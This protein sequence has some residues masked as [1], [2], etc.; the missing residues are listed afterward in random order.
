MYRRD[1]FAPARNLFVIVLI[2]VL[3]NSAGS[4]PRHFALGSAI[5]IPLKT[6]L[7]T[8][9]QGRAGKD[10]DLLIIGESPGC[11]AQHE[12]AKAQLVAPEGSPVAVLETKTQADCNIT[13]RIRIPVDAGIGHVTLWV[14]ND[15]GKL[16]GTV[17]F[18]IVDFTPPGQIPPGVNPPAVDVMWSVMP[19]K[20]VGDNFGSSI[21]RKYYAI[22]IIIG[23]NSAYNLQLVSVG[24]E[25][26]SDREIEG[27][28][29]RN[30]KNKAGIQM[31]SRNQEAITKRV[32]EPVKDP[33]KTLSTENEIPGSEKRTLLPTSSYKITRG[34][35]EA[36]QLLYP[37]T[38]ILSTIT[39]LGPIFTGFTPY[40]HNVN[41][42]GNFT[43]AIN[44]FSNPLEKGLEL[45]WPD[46]RPHQRDRFDDQVLRDG[47]IIKN[48]TQV[49][50]LAFFPKE[51]LRL[52]GNVESEAEYNAWRNNAREVRERLGE[53][54]IIGDLIQYVNRISLTP[55]PP[56]PVNP[57]PTINQPNPPKVKQ[58]VRALPIT[59]TGSNLAGA[60]LS[61]K[62]T[63]GI[64]FQSIHVDENG[65]VITATVT[66]EDSVAPN[67]YGIVVTTP[68]G[69][70]DEAD[71]IVE[72]EQIGD[73]S[74]QYK[75]PKEGETNPVSI[76]ITGKFLHHAQ[77]IAPGELTVLP[78]VIPSQDGTSVKANV[79][80]KPTTKAGK[81][82][83]TVFDPQFP[84]NRKQ[85][86]FE[87]LPKG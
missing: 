33:S 55:N 50:T 69:G 48:N 79:T 58:G 42:R 22:E 4:T 52:P 85:V 49:R 80:L 44:I 23:N 46:P 60:Q 57:P 71:L 41:H 83:L 25:L 15:K 37:R 63:T 35:L 38:L 12:L 18:S 86:E 31:A 62:G 16:L 29:Q 28:L 24:F 32:L 53:I 54:V 21:A 6:Y 13:A 39:A 65:R 17:Q 87:V 3:C 82:K 10:Y 64:S 40:F 11:E 75:K 47:L 30:A 73:V 68:Q 1:L 84:E 5:Q 51:L 76:E 20:I 67:T 2:V 81:Y 19:K 56:G 43:E 74:I 77:I 36:R 9:S 66:V 45:V 14:T 27:W 59:I 26:P 70:H 78:D 34:S 7:V 72:A 8:P 61:P